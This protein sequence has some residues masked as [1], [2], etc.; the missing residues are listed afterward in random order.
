MRS[1]SAMAIPLGVCTACSNQTAAPVPPPP[2][3]DSKS[4]PSVPAKRTAETV[5]NMEPPWSPNAISR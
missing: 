1:L 4:A 5:P 2:A 3:T